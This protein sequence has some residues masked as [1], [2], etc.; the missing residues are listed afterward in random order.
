VSLNI[1]IDPGLSG[2]LA[3]LS[4]DGTPE[5]LADLP[6][7]RDRSL[8]WIDG[9]E[10][11]SLI[12]GALGG[13]G[14]AAMVERVSSMPG[15]GIASSFQFGIGFGSILGVLQ[16]LHIRIEFVTAV[17]WKRSYGLSKDKHASLH[18]AR[19]MFPTAELHLAKHEGRAEAL[20]I[21]HYA[22][23]RSARA[24]ASP[25]PAVPAQ[26]STPEVRP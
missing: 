23:G 12:V 14:A 22:I 2:A 24:A 9:S 15:Q 16:A 6:I 10:L 1:G 26:R 11:Q 7:V 8:A 19:L 21:A 5:L 17:V 4:S 3:I 25:A 20:L 18:K 13:R